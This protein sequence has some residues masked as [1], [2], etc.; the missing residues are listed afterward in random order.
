MLIQFPG[1]FLGAGNCLTGVDKINVYIG[2]LICFSWENGGKEKNWADEWKMKLVTDGGEA[3]L[4]W[5]GDGVLSEEPQFSSKTPPW[6]QG[7]V[8]R[9]LNW[10]EIPQNNPG[11]LMKLRLSSWLPGKCLWEVDDVTWRAWAP[12]ICPEVLS[13]D[14]RVWELR[15]K[16]RLHWLFHLATGTCR[17]Y[18][19]PFFAKIIFI[20]LLLLKSSDQMVCSLH[21]SRWLPSF[22]PPNRSRRQNEDVARRFFILG[23]SCCFRR[24]QQCFIGSCLK[25]NGE[26][27]I[28]Y[29]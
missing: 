28:C 27:M 4:L 20:N 1:V 5:L 16:S 26:V 2:F 9:M 6:Q 22:P 29:Y 24:F 19:N 8:R 23:F 15:C 11:A 7:A 3:V 17:M 13:L 18:F 10:N 21:C 25:I 14:I 12:D